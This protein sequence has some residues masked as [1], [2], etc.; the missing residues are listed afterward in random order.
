M[1]H[2]YSVAKFAHTPMITPLPCT[3]NLNSVTNPQPSHIVWLRQEGETS[4]QVRPVVNAFC[5]TGIH[6]WFTKTNDLHAEHILFFDLIIVDAIG[7]RMVDSLN[8]VHD[9][10][11]C[12]H[13]PVLLYSDSTDINWRVHA[14]RA[15][16]DAILAA[17]TAPQVFLARCQAMLRRWR[18]AS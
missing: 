14:F 10:R 11:V 3:Y 2:R 15:G 18:A 4:L 8:I 13:A 9:I 12:S 7:P 1:N 6:V 16:A 5:D 17:D